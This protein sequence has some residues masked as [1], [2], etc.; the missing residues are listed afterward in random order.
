M[1]EL[2]QKGQ[3]E[4]YEILLPQKY[5]SMPLPP[6]PAGIKTGGWTANNGPQLP[7]V[8]SI[9]QFSSPQFTSESRKDMRQALVNY[10]AGFVDAFGKKVGG[11]TIAERGPTESGK[12]NGIQ[13]TRF[14][15]KGTGPNRI[16]MRGAAYGMIDGDHAVMI[17]VMSFGATA[18]SEVH[19]L[20]SAM[21]TFNKQ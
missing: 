21:A 13:F 4:D 9:T 7:S 16:D 10:S 1:N 14:V 2:K 12:V 19:L 15:F 11:I 5:A 3:F 6:T 18:E 20:E 8:L 17:M